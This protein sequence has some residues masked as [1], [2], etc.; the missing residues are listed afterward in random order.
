MYTVGAYYFA[1]FIAEIPAG[2]VV[3]FVFGSIIYFI[4]G[5]NQTLWW[6]F[7]VF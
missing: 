1:K 6:K 2:I 7:L 5:L 3:P 4:V